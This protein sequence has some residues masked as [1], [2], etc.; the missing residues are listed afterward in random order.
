MP[1]WGLIE[2][3]MLGANYANICGTIYVF[4]F[5]IIILIPVYL[6]ST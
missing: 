6:A 4:D 5:R 1:I 2:F 3:S